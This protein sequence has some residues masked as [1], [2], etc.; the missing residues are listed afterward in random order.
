[1]HRGRILGELWG[2]RRVPGLAGRKLVVCTDGDADRV[3]VAIDTLDARPGQ[4]ALV[5]FGSG[6]RNVLAMQHPFSSFLPGPLAALINMPAAPLAGD[7]DMPMVQNPRHG[8]SERLVV[9][10]GHEAEG[11]FNMPGGQSGHP[12][13]PYYRA[14]HE[15]WVQGRPTPLQ[16]G[17]VRHTLVL[18]P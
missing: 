15:A 13:S 9:S 11:I 3:V 2:A 16:P 18:K 7:S 12:M 5:A 10:P 17:P 4:E 6:A 14:G 8:Q 1:M